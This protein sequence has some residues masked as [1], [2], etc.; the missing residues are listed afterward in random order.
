[1]E[2]FVELRPFLNGQI[3]FFFFG[4]YFVHFFLLPRRLIF[5]SNVLLEILASFM[6][7]LS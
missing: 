4:A 1:M 3:F 2:R 7:C 5:F 6:Y